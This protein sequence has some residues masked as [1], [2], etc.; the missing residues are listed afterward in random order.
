MCEAACHL[1]KADEAHNG[2]VKKKTLWSKPFFLTLQLMS[3][4][5]PV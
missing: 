3:E 1:G 2:W 5:P 4:P